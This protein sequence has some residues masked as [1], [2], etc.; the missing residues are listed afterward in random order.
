MIPLG[1]EDLA[2]AGFVR[3]G[4]FMLAGVVGKPSSERAAVLRVL[5]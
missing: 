5:L 4:R 2:V 1:G 3:D